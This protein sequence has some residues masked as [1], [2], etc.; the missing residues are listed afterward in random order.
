[1]KV[2]QYNEEQKL[3]RMKK[4]EENIKEL[5][6]PIKWNNMTNG[7]PRKRDKYYILIERITLTEGIS[8]TNNPNTQVWVKKINP[9]IW[10]AQRNT[11]R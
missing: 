6:D 10:K 2:I 5:L 3:K 7:S 1:M 9:Q 4:H 11:C 8:T